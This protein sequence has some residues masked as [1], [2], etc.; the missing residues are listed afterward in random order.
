MVVARWQVV[1]VT[2]LPESKML[3]VRPGMGEPVFLTVLEEDLVQRVGTRLTLT[4][5]VEPTESEK[6]PKP[7]CQCL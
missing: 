2:R 6:V 4:V 1:V 3:H 5:E 7:P